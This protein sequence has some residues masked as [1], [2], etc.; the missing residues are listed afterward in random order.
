MFSRSFHQYS[1]N[2]EI[3]TTWSV[4]GTGR[5]I[6][7]QTRFKQ[8]TSTSIWLLSYYLLASTQSNLPAELIIFLPNYQDYFFIHQKKILL[9]IYIRDTICLDIFTPLLNSKQGRLELFFKDIPF[10]YLM[11]VYHATSKF[12]GIVYSAQC[13]LS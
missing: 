10:R 8:Q 7:S 5:L 3:E 2:S 6:W 9:F 4:D 13:W 1:W 12:F 11:A